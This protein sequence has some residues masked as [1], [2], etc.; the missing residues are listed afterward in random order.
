MTNK[1][2]MPVEMPIHSA[3]PCG[4]N[5]TACFIVLNPL[6]LSSGWASIPGGLLSLLFTEFSKIWWCLSQVSVIGKK[7]RICLS[8]ANENHW[9]T[10]KNTF[11]SMT[12]ISE[13]ITW[14]RDRSQTQRKMLI[15]WVIFMALWD[16][17]YSSVLEENAD[18]KDG[19]PQPV[20]SI[21]HLL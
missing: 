3:G 19:K 17:H 15:D 12:I 10:R 18:L 4:W 13:A 11:N 8:I 21:T 20:Q 2:C 6:F 5:Q 1:L 16:H 9:G 7:N 14:Q